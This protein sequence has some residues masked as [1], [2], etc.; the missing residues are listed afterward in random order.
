VLPNYLI[1]YEL[2]HA[3]SSLAYACTEAYNLG[4][5]PVTY[6][7]SGPTP[8]PPG[9]P[10]FDPRAGNDPSVP[11]TGQNTYNGLDYGPAPNGGTGFYK[12][13]SGNELPNAPH[14]TASLTADYT[15]PLSPDWAAT[16]HS[17]FY[18][19]ASSW[20]RVFNA[21][22]DNIEGY[23][24][25][26]MALILTDTSGWQ[27][28]AYVKNVFDVTAITG[29]FL[30][31]DDTG[32][33][34]NIFLTDPRLFG[35]RVTKQFDG[36]SSGG[37]IFGS[38]AGKHPTTWITVG[39]NFAQLQADWDKFNPA[40]ASAMPAGLP[41]PTITE[42]APSASFDWEGN[43]SIQ[44]ED[45][46][47]VLKAGIRYGRATR[48]QNLHKSLPAVTATNVI[49]PT[50]VANYLGLPTKISCETFQQ[51][52]PTRVCPFAA[53]DPEFVDSQ[54]KESE[55][56]LMIDFTLGKD[57]G[58]GLFGGDGKG[59]IGAGVRMAQ[60]TTDIR[61]ELNSDPHYNFPSPLTPFTGGQ[62]LKYGNVYDGKTDEHRT[63]RGIGPE[64]TWDASQP[65]L[66]GGEEGE[67]NLDWGVNAALLFGRQK[68]SIH[69]TRMHKECPGFNGFAGVVCTY[70]YNTPTDIPRSRSVVVPN[71]G[72]YIGASAQYRNAKINFGYR[73]DVFFDAMDGGQGSAKSYSRGFYGPYLNVSLGLGG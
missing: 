21:D 72:G 62:A 46:D 28:M 19:Q 24:T 66:G 2:A 17:D 37:D 67:L 9:Y 16:L 48:K 10:G 55:Q 15:V 44:P 65:V 61:A 30:N 36:G 32:L 68:V 7:L 64:I 6:T 13:V 73:A 63:F 27:A 71:L 8:L 49:I 22:M 70:M 20:A 29:T 39:G 51:L 57:V 42:K 5:D 41:N 26:N 38:I 69:Q 40:F 23:K 18:W 35:V 11:Y 4:V 54:A 25:V 52:A 31:S 53:Y 34:T 33:T 14:Y 45:S 47:W 1:A 43:I 50:Y 3:A 58:I 56:H 12:D 59:T 60:F